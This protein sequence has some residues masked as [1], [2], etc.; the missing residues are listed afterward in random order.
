MSHTLR[1]AIVGLGRIAWEFHLPEVAAKRDFE[2][3]GVVDP[4]A[5]RRAE[6]RTTFGVE[7]YHNLVELYAHVKPDL[8]VIASPTQFHAEQS[9]FALEHGSDVFCDKPLAASLA[10]ADRIITAM[11]DNGRKLMLYQPHRATAE[12]LALRHIIAKD[13]LG[14]VYMMKRTSCQYVRRNDWQAFKRYAG[15][16]LNNYGSHLVD[17]LLY[18]ANS[19]AKRTTC[20]M[21]NIATLGDAEDV[22]KILIETQAGIL[23]DIDI[24][25]ATA[26]ALPSWQ[27][28]GARGTAVLDAEQGVWNVRYFG[29]N[30]L[31]AVELHEDLAAP[32]R[33]YPSDSNIP[34]QECAVNLSDFPALDYYQ[35]CYAYF[36]RGELPFVPIDESRELMR[37]LD[38]CRLD[39]GGQLA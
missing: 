20:R 3:V 11:R 38:I 22:V 17:Q 25:Q 29:A 23:L 27:V 16:M 35:K 18:I 9:I 36:A 33:E 32:G 34:W 28:F 30:A 37:V 1:T 4:L 12:A 19:A 15:G 6:A 2:L 5:E 13:L 8:V 31:P 24:N 7:G 14:T 10:E 26:Y 21:Q 39:D